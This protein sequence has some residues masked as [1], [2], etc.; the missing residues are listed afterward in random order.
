MTENQYY[1]S[2]GYIEDSD[3]DYEGDEWASEPVQV[4][5]I[6]ER[7]A[8]EYCGC[9]TWVIPQNTI[10]QPVQILQRRL[11]RHKGKLMLTAL[12]GATSV[13][14]NSKLDPL[15]GLS[16]QGAAVLVIGPLPDWESQQPLY[17]IAV[18]GGPATVAVWDEA[19]AER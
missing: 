3:Q 4:K 9:M 5:E 2:S 19:Y 6:S 7:A 11:R 16:P 10:G 14:F 13:V 18:G 1:T 15:Q 12:G 8:P 17:A